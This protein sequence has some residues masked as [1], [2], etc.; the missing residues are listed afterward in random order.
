M[1]LVVLPDDGFT[2]IIAALKKAKSSIDTTVFRSDRL[3]IEKA[4]EQAVARGVRVRALIAQT[5]RGGEKRLRKLELRLLGA[6]VTVARSGDDL[7][8]YHSKMLIIDNRVLYVMLFNYTALDAKSRSFAVI[9]K[10]HAQVKEATRLFESDVTRQPFS[11]SK[12]TLVISPDNARQTLAS[13]IEASKKELCIYDPDI[14]DRAMLKLLEDRAK[15]GVSIRVIGKMSKRAGQLRA[16]RLPKRRLH[17]RVIISDGRRAF[18]G[19]QGLRR[20][21]LDARREVGVIVHDA[22]LVKTLQDVFESDWAE[23]PTAQSLKNAV[24]TPDEKPAGRKD[25]AQSAVAG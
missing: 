3:E 16:E 5:N 23:T 1:K 14:T 4:F 22:R 24:A 20:A 18:L 2:P 25:E 21:E 13:F 8:R 12:H 6:G 7:A 19:S 10:N 11:A 9:S 17:A 15:K